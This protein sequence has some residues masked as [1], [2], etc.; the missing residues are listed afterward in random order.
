MKYMI[1]KSKYLV[2]L[3]VLSFFL[4]FSVEVSDVSAGIFS[5]IT[6]DEFVAVITID[7]DGDMYVNETWYMDYSEGYNVRFRDIVY[8]KFPSNYTL[9]YSEKNTTSFSEHEY[10]VEVYKSGKD[11]TSQVEVGYSF[12]GD[13]DERNEIILCPI[14]TEPLCESIFINFEDIGG[15]EGDMKIQYNYVIKNVV[16]EYSDISE[17]NWVLFNYAESGIDFGTVDI[18]LP[19]NTSKVEDIDVFT[20]LV[21]HSNVEVKS[22]QNITINFKNMKKDDQLGFRLL[23]P[24]NTFS[25][26]ADDN[27]FIHEAMNRQVIINF[28]EQLALESK[29]SSVSLYILIGISIISIFYYGYKIDKLN[30]TIFAPYNTLDLNQEIYAR[31]TNHKPA[32]VGYFYHN[33]TSSYEDISA[34][35]LDLISRGYFIV[36]DSRIFNDPNYSLDELIKGEKARLEELKNK[37]NDVGSSTS[38]KLNKTYER[39]DDYFDMDLVLNKEMSS[40]DL[41]PYEIHLV[42]WY[43]NVIGD[44]KKV[45]TKEMINLDNL[46]ES[47]RYIAES[48]KFNRLVKESCADTLYY[49][50]LSADIKKSNQ[51]AIPLGILF[52]ITIISGIVF[53]TNIAAPMLIY[54]VIAGVYAIFVN[55]R[56]RKTFFIHNFNEKWSRYKKNLARI[57]ILKTAGITDVEFWD[58]NLIY[59]TVFGIAEEVLVQLQSVYD[60]G[61]GV[62]PNIGMSTKSG[63]NNFYYHSFWHRYMRTYQRKIYTRA[64]ANVNPTSSYVRRSGAS[65]GFSRGGSF[66][67]GGGGGRSR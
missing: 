23:V 37:H 11:F 7:S 30:K 9:P 57:N 62:K 31:P 20:A 63:Y 67:G 24:S 66:G 28:E 12:K 18:F 6:I 43:I 21:R 59:A 52:V 65:G 58:E 53:K 40:D 27:I 51:G 49:D 16:T 22:N 54:I 39:I 25:S 64:N 19:N 3:V 1:Y 13:L 26:I 60:V 46:E 48:L 45:S 50:D 2:L 10:S 38:I 17:I 61:D 15:L 47:S 32:V 8:R 4:L 56:S 33:R 34:T 41:E 29:L 14:G 5:K 36:D 35:L 55:T 44:G 42:N